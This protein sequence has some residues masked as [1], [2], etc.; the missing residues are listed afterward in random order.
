MRVYLS[1]YESL[2]QVWLS[3]PIVFMALLMV[4]VFLF[5][6]GLLAALKTLKE[7]SNSVCLKMND[8]LDNILNT[9]SQVNRATQEVIVAAMD[10][11]VEL[12]IKLSSLCISVA[13]ALIGLMIELYL[14]T[15]ACLLTALIKGTLNL[16]TEII[17]AITETVE[18]AINT[19]T[20]G[21]NTALSG[22]SSAINGFITGLSAVKSLFTLNNTSSLTLAVSSVTLSASALKNISIPNT[23]VEEIS[24]LSNSIP[25]FEEVLSNLTSVV[26]KPLDMLDMKIKLLESTKNLTFSTVENV[27]FNVLGDTCSSLEIIFDIAAAKA[28]SCSNIIFVVLAGSL[29]VVLCFSIWREKQVWERKIELFRQLALENLQVDVGNMIQRNENW[30]LRPFMSRWDSRFQWWISYMNTPILLRCAM[31]GICGLIGFGLQLLILQ[32]ISKAFEDL[33]SQTTNGTTT[34]SKVASIVGSFVNQT[35][36]YIESSQSL[37][38]E[39]LLDPILELGTELYST[40]LKIELAV[41]IT[42]NSIFGDSFLADPLRTIVYCT[43]GRKLET[44]EDGLTWITKNTQLTLFNFSDSTYNATSEALVDDVLLSVSAFGANVDSATKHLI[45]QYRGILQI[46]LL[47][48]CAFLG[49]WLLV[50]IMGGVFL[51]IREFQNRL[52]GT[53]SIG[54]PI[55]LS[56][57][58]KQK[59]GYPIRDPFS[60]TASSIYSGERRP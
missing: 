38:D 42:I 56:E 21:I 49:V 13:K 55:Q 9:L 31:I 28:Q 43:I 19:A 4:K 25:D 30:L 26:T 50:A 51:A 10:S 48:S 27:S 52:H 2:S 35:E 8:M 20:E 33:S 60:L 22:L 40:I 11:T 16:V 6:R 34:R 14:G 53:Q 5:T 57:K 37:V 46:E 44:I 17:S 3:E 45:K 1:L 41:N 58:Q 18:D 39:Q 47:T 32:A 23:F 7:V 36:S 12:V 15:L 29:F 24:N 59:L 54:M